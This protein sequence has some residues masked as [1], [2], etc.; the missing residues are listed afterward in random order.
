VE[1]DWA[2][3]LKLELILVLGEISD[4][5]GILCSCSNV[6]HIDSNVLIDVAILLHPNVKFSYAWVEAH[7][8]ETVSKVIMPMEARSPDSIECLED[9]E[10]VSFQLTK[11]RACNN[12]DLLLSF[13]LKI[14]IDNVNSP[15]IKIIELGQEDKE[16]DSTEGNNTRIDAVK[17]DLSEMSISNKP[18]LVDLLCFTS[19]TG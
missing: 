14:S 9:D 1:A 7:V 4:S 18:A 15:D 3:T 2:C 17:W 8:P 19:K 12:V 10:G 13:C 16:V 5:L 11:F 6:I